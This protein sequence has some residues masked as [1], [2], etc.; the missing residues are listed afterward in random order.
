M[1]PIGEFEVSQVYI[2]NILL[3]SHSTY[4]PSPYSEHCLDQPRYNRSQHRGKFPMAL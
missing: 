4:E 2:C 1:F 3:A